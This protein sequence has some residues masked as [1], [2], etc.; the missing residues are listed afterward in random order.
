[1]NQTRLQNLSFQTRGEDQS[2]ELR[3]VTTRLTALEHECADKEQQLFRSSHSVDELTAE[4][5]RLE[6]AV[7]HKQIM[8][9]KL[10]QA[11]K[12]A[13]QEVNKGNEIIQKLQQEM[14]NTKTRLRLKSTVAMEQEKAISERELGMK[15]VSNELEITQKEC[16]RAKEE[17]KTARE[18]LDATKKE[19]FEC[20][21][22]MKTNENVISWLNKQLNDRA[23]TRTQPL[24]A[25][26]NHSLPVTSRIPVHAP[27]A[28]P[29]NP[30][31]NGV[32]S[33]HPPLPS[34]FQLQ[35]KKKPATYSM[36]GELTSATMDDFRSSQQ[37]PVNPVTNPNLTPPLPRAATSREDRPNL[38]EMSLDPKYLSKTIPQIP[39]NPMAPLSLNR[40]MF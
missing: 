21:E 20:Q 14:H 2:D 1:M 10:E 29:L 31:Y 27:T 28:L 9:V 11:V 36:P 38:V 6:T 18:D 15:R 13:S 16:A 35:Y 4:R 12:T 30:L 8:L 39:F 17:R 22:Q 7:Q 32:P 25:S 5:V 40:P 26:M 24:T 3:R 19:L 33:L 34:Q 37:L 23:L